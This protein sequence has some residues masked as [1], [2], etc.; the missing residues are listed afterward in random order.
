MRFFGKSDRTPKMVLQT[1]AVLL[2]AALAAGAASAILANNKAQRPGAATMAPVP[3]GTNSA[4]LPPP[5]LVIGRAV[6]QLAAYRTIEATVHMSAR[7]FDH[8]LAGSG[9][10]LEQ[11]TS[12]AVKHRLDLI[13]QF[14]GQGTGL[15]QVCDGRWLWRVERLPDACSASRIDLERLHDDLANMQALGQLGGKERIAYWQ[16]LADLLV[17]LHTEYLFQRAVP[18]RLASGQLVWRLVGHCRTGLPT[19][20]DRASARNLAGGVSGEGG[21]SPGPA[22]APVQRNHMPSEVV[23]DVHQH[24]GIPLRIEYTWNRCDPAGQGRAGRADRQLVLEFAQVR[25]N[26]RPG[27]PQSAFEPPAAD[28]VDRTGEYLEE[29]SN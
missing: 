6:R 13:S 27:F 24:T 3:N 9:R 11:R 20:S 10:Y 16:S 5:D 29:L 25:I 15:C 1:P 28:Y 8:V 7:L 26:S 4:V 19:N 23:I 21:R 12:S 2:L 17:A 18:V 22:A 14:E